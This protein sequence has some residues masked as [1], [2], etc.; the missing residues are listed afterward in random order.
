MLLLRTKYYSL[1]RFFTFLF[2][3]LYLF[4]LD[5]LGFLSFQQAPSYFSTLPYFCFCRPTF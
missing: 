5:N 3:H 1:R 2:T 4:F